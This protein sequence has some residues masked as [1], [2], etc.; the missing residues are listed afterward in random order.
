MS[1]AIHAESIYIRVIAA[2]SDIIC[3]ILFEVSRMLFLR[4]VVCMLL[5]YAF[6]SASNSTSWHTVVLKKPVLSQQVD[7]DEFE[8]S[9]SVTVPSANAGMVHVYNYHSIIILN[10]KS[11]SFR[12]GILYYDYDVEHVADSSVL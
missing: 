7:Y 6:A 4:I 11:L 12:I 3:T 9:I 1:D 5:V 8:D 10:P 2:G